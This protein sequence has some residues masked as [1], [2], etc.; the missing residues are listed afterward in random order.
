MGFRIAGPHIVAFLEYVSNQYPNASSFGD[1]NE[2]DLGRLIERFM[3]SLPQGVLSR[4][5]D[6]SMMIQHGFTRIA[7]V[8]YSVVQEYDRSKAG[9]HPRADA[10][11][12]Y[13]KSRYK[14]IFLYTE[15]DTAFI[16]YFIDQWRAI[17]RESGSL[18]HFFDY[19]VDSNISK[20]GGAARDFYTYTEE[21]IRSLSAIPGLTVRKVREAGLPCCIVWNADGESAI[22]PLSHTEDKTY[23]RRAIRTMLR[24][25]ERDQLSFVNRDNI[26][27]FKSLEKIDV[28][29]SY[30]RSDY[31]WV[32]KLNSNMKEL[33]VNTWID[34]LLEPSDR[35]D[36][37]IYNMLCRAKNVVVVWSENSIRSEYVSAEAH[38]ARNERKLIPVSKSR[39][40]EP[41][42]PFNIVQSI[43]LSEWMPGSRLPER[44]IR[45]IMPM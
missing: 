40:V 28:F 38:F 22:F 16:E 1:I 45:S 5:Q 41:P 44:L 8:G 33:G 7:E 26:R 18:L 36:S 12:H 2:V 23:F 4:H 24:I 11:E 31:E 35:W 29:I 27:R 39:R 32:E 20:D 42:V 21:Y 17:D 13:K 9:A 6:L 25:L 34:Q 43:D 19:G 14:G 15:Q 30:Q 10:L 3:N 37:T